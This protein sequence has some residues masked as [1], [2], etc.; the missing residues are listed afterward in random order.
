MSLED[1]QLLQRSLL[2]RHVSSLSQILPLYISVQHSHICCLELITSKTLI[3]RE[4][5]SKLLFRLANRNFSH[6]NLSQFAFV[7]SAFPVHNPFNKS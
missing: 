5:E 6:G 1:G 7:F 4:Y 3:F 2:R